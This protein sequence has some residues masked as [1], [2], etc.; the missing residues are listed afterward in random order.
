MDRPN[1]HQSTEVQAET[2][3]QAVEPQGLPGKSVG[4]DRAWAQNRIANFFK[5]QQAGRIQ[6]KPQDPG[7]AKRLRRAMK[8]T[9]S[10]QKRWNKLVLLTQV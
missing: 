8:R 7:G 2:P 4:S 6:R 1:K 9:P 3:G 5:G 10:L